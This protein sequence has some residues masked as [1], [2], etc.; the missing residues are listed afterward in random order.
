MLHAKE[1]TWLVPVICVGDHA[2]AIEDACDVF[3]R[4]VAAGQLPGHQ[5]SYSRLQLFGCA[6]VISR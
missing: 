6:V 1:E 3:L 5:V 4:P 2:V